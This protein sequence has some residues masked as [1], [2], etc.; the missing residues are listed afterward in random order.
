MIATLPLADRTFSAEELIPLL[1]CD[2][3]VPQLLCEAVVDRAISQIHC[4]PEEIDRS[5]QGFYR[6]WQLDSDAKRGN[7]R[8]R[9]G[10]TQTQLEQLATRKLR[11]EKFKQATWGYQIDSEFLERKRQIDRA[12]YSLIRT[13]DLGL[14][15][16]LYFRILEG[17]QSFA[18]LARQYSEGA[19]S[20]T[21][22]LV[23]PI[24]FGTLNPHFAEF[25]YTCS[26]GKVQPPIGF[27]EWQLLVRLEK[28]VPAQ[29]DE[30]M[31]Q[32]LLQEKFDA[33][34]KKQLQELSDVDRLWMGILPRQVSKTSQS[35][36]TTRSG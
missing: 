28:I 24:E 26:P 36:A 30:S 1:V 5:C 25:L 7:W 18:E 10:L 34:L 33:W 14:A 13:K 22:G 19:E 9:Y 2:E 31:R 17:E 3:L 12:I 8:S 35:L 27:G 6:Y 4:T 16:E 15:I 20:D 21:N 32:R 29:L 23:G 11:I